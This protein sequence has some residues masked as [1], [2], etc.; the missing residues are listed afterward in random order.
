LLNISVVENCN[1]QRSCYFSFFYK[2][3]VFKAISHHLCIVYDQ[4][5]NQQY[6]KGFVLVQQ[7]VSPTFGVFSQSWPLWADYRNGFGSLTGYF[8]IGNE[9]LHQLTS[10]G[11]CS[12]VRYL[13]YCYII[14]TGETLAIHANA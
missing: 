1:L 14:I 5:L 8:W 7:R 9:A 2:F 12:S 3:C 11:A 4:T 10:S 6:L 13:A